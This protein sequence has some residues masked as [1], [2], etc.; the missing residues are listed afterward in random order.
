MSP[1]FFIDMLVMR[2]ILK[3]VLLVLIC[4]VSAFYANA[5]NGSYIFNHKLVASILSESYGIPA[6]VI[7]AVAAVESSGGQGPAA[8]VL[9]NHFGIVGKNSFINKRG[10]SSRYK[11][12]NNELASYLDFCKLISHKRFYHKLKGN[13][14]CIAWVKA[15][16]NCGYSEQPEQW[17]QK[18]L[19]VLYSMKLQSSYSLAF[20]K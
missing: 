3:K 11:E 12:Y 15:I 7:L 13:T 5:Q 16:S 10:H 19:S 2:R 9:N 4:S 18:V 20:G 8:K 14:D 6:S 1:A 17:K